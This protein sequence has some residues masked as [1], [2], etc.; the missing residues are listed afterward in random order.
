MKTIVVALGGNALQ[1]KGGEATAQEQLSV[2][3]DTAKSLV[4]LVKAG[5][6]LVIVH[7]NGPQV[8]RILMQNEAASHLTPAMP[9]DVCGAMSQGMIGYHIQQALG[10][11]LAEEGLPQ[12]PVTLVSQVVVDPGDPAFK[13][14]T[15]P[16]GLFYHQDEAGRIAQEKG[17]TFKEDAGRGW[18]RVVPSP[19]PVEI[20]E[21]NQVKTLMNQGFVPIAAGGGGIPVA[22]DS[23]GKLYGVDAVIDKD[24]AA[25]RLADDLNADALLILTEV[26]HACLHYGKPGQQTLGRVSADELQE[27][28]NQGHF[29]AGSM[30]PKAEAALRFVS[31]HK[32]RLAIITRLDLAL[33]SLEGARGT[34]IV[35]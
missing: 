28:L 30:G 11:L 13:N 31:G 4:G 32:G 7:G 17:Y 16:I 19:M 2:V 9:F 3:H 34:Q 10:E 27:Y 21:L 12:R 5:W 22:R 25:C 14:P 24:L 18:R 20:V 15:K 26:E 35:D 33:E 6:Q 29:A 1:R 23:A 8:G